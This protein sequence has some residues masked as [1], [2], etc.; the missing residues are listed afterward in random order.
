MMVLIGDN[1]NYHF[2][3]KQKYIFF[4]YIVENIE[5]NETF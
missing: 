3:G 4:K 5:E 1:M 2:V